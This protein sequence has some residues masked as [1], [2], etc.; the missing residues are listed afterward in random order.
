[1]RFASDNFTI[2]EDPE[3]AP[4]QVDDVI[5]DQSTSRDYGAIGQSTSRDNGAIN[6]EEEEE[7]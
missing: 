6:N 2:N 4:E 3:T 1:M 7:V 5:G